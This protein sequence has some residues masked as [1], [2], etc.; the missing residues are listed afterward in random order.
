MYHHQ[1]IVD[2]RTIRSPAQVLNFKVHASTSESTSESS[3]GSVRAGE[4]ILKDSITNEFYSHEILKIYE[5][6]EIIRIGLSIEGFIVPKN[7][8]FLGPKWIRVAKLAKGIHE[9]NAILEKS[10]TGGKLRVRVVKTIEKDSE[11]FLWFSEEVAAL[12]R[13]N[14]LRLDNFQGHFHYRCHEC[15]KIFENP[16]PLKIHIA[17]NCDNFPIDLL[18]QR[19]N[20]ALSRII[21]LPPNTPQIQ[22]YS[23]AFRSIYPQHQASSTTPSTAVPPTSM[24]AASHLETIVSNMGTSKDGHI[25][26]YCGKLYSRKYGLKIHI[27]THT[28]FK[29]LKCKYCFRPF[30]DPSNLNKH[31]RLHAQS[32]ATHK[33]NLCNKVMVRKRDLERHNQTRHGIITP[34]LDVDTTTSEE[35]IEILCD[36]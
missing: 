24:A 8:I 22:S 33:C 20:D 29:P 23:G 13:I 2:L 35:D 26:I 15:H 21:Q 11:V 18:Y 32:G 36:A 10:S 12:M 30:G 19:L 5:E 27:R 25:C 17:T 9:G 31:L 6:S 28:G 14:F 4:E 7:S 34:G 3:K 16:N 1:S